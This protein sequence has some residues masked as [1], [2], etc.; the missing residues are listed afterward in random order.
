MLL[1]ACPRNKQKEDAN[2]Y[3]LHAN[4]YCRF[5]VMINANMKKRRSTF[6]RKRITF[7]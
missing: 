7:K 1:D 6:Y 2:G 4:G 3:L 5:L